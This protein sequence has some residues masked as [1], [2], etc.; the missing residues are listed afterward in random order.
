M[1]RVKGGT[2]TH[3]RHK[4][5]LDAAKG[6]YGRRKNTFKTARRPSTRPTSTRPATARQRKRNFRAL[7]IQ[8]INAAVRSHD[9]ALTYCA[10]HQRPGAGRD[11]G[12]PQGA[13][14]SGR[15]R[16]GGVWRHRREGEG[17]ARELELEEQ[18]GTSRAPGGVATRRPGWR[19]LCSFGD[20]GRR[21]SGA[22]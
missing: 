8:R 18:F 15:A 11:R 6:Y 21:L 5:V 13:G 4:K 17:C 3:A 9:E 14:R 2:V 19:A 12:R 10:L 16:A 7:W 22:G 20:Q 1:S